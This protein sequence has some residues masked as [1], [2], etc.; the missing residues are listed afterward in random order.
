MIGR[1]ERDALELRYPPVLTD[2][3]SSQLVQRL[4]AQGQTLLS[5]VGADVDDGHDDLGLGVTLGAEPDF[6]LGR[7]GKTSGP[8]S[9]RGGERRE[10]EADRLAAATAV[11]VA[12]VG[13]ADEMSTLR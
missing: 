10:V 1:R 6:G 3:G 7:G 11:V 12:P 9:Q 5:E 4:K 2:L 8:G 13:R